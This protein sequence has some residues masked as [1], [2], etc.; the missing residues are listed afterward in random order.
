MPHANQIFLAYRMLKLCFLNRKY[1]VLELRVDFVS[2]FIELSY[3][4]ILERQ[5]GDD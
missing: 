5:S 4:H 1:I 2:H 3:S